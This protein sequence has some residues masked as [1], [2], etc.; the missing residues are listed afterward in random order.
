L[1]ALRQE[2]ESMLHPTQQF[3]AQLQSAYDGIRKQSGHL[4]SADKPRFDRVRG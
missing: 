2:A 1:L 3:A 4:A